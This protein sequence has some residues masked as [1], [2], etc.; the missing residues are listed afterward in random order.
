[1]DEVRRLIDSKSLLRLALTPL[2]CVTYRVLNPIYLPNLD[3]NC[4]VEDLRHHPCRF[5]YGYERI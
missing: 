1:M 5:R 3:P 4:I 2:S